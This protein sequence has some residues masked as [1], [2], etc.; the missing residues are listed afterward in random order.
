MTGDPLLAHLRMGLANGLSA[1]ELAEVVTHVAF[2]VGWP[3]AWEAFGQLQ[4]VLDER[5]E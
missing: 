1:D 2:Y 3:R 4:R 5:E